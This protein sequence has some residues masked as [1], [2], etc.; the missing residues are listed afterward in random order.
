MKTISRELS[1]L[2][3]L[4]ILNFLSIIA[5]VWPCNSVLACVYFVIVST[6][7]RKR[8]RGDIFFVIICIIKEISR[9]EGGNDKEKTIENEKKLPASSRRS[10]DLVYPS[11]VFP[12]CVHSVNTHFGGVSGALPG[13]FL[14][15]RE[16]RRQWRVYSTVSIGSSI[17]LSHR[18]YKIVVCLWFRLSIKFLACNGQ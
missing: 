2:W 5:I 15:T 12:A 13:V 11:T 8:I 4:L 3:Q 14:Q 9:C 18:I 17:N 16:Y 6:T 7:I 10:N 1:K